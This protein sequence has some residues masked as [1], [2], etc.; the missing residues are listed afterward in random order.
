MTAKSK[1]DIKAF[2]ETGDKPTQA[3]F[4]D[5]IDS[6]VD[7]A[8]PIGTIE[9]AASAGTVGLAAF[10]GGVGSISSYD[11]ARNSMGV[12]VYTTALSAGV[13]TGLIAT[14]AQATAATSNSTLMTPL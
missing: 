11:A 13:I 5:T 7:A 8:G 6:W 3:Q 1:T 4:I 2:F 9:A 14:T 12:T 10:T